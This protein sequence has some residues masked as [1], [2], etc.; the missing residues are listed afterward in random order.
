MNRAHN[1]DEALHSIREAQPAGFN[2]I[3]I[4]LIYGIPA[5]DHSLWRQDVEQLFALNVQHVSCYALT[6]E[7]QTVLGNWTRKGKFKPAEDEF[8]AQQFEI[9]LEEMQRHG[10]TQYEISNFCNFLELSQG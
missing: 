1:S 8:T 6:V 9:L 10:F 2:N 3:S 4:G 5:P 7:P